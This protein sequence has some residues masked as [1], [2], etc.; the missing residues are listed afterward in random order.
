MLE[1]LN[2]YFEDIEVMQIIEDL[3]FIFVGF[4]RC[5][6]NKDCPK[7][8]DEEDCEFDVCKQDQFRCGN[9]QCISEAKKCDFNFDCA[10]RSDEMS[11]INK[12]RGDFSF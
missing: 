6:G 7:G 4:H 12:C 5:D 8:E 11:C 1:G 2:L 9:G 10:D 3:L